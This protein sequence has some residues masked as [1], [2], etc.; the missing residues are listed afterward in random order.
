MKHKSRAA[1]LSVL[2]IL[3]LAFLIYALSSD[4]LPNET[5][6]PVIAKS[7][8]YFLRLENNEIVIYKDGK[9]TETG[10]AVSGLREQDRTLL[11]NGLKVDSYENVLKLIEDFSS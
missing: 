2:I 11:E 8:E 3:S 4:N 1:L 7:S 10:I 5:A 6:S 9:S